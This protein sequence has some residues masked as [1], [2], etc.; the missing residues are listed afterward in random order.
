LGASRYIGAAIHQQSLKIVQHIWMNVNSKLVC[1][2]LI[3]LFC[4]QPASQFQEMPGNKALFL[5]AVGKATQG[6]VTEQVWFA[7]DQMLGCGDAACPALS[8]ETVL[9]LQ[10]PR[11]QA[12]CL[13][14]WI[15]KNELLEECW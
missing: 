6:L 4:S 7:V 1:F 13:L 9:N 12:V 10:L 5:Q 2:A 11:S 3:Q 8:H 14:V 15:A